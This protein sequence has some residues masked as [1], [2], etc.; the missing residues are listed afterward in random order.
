MYFMFFNKQWFER[1]ICHLIQEHCAVHAF[2]ICNINLFADI[3][4]ATRLV[5]HQCKQQLKCVNV[6]MV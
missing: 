5:L 1:E 4:R 3:S 2:N 6:L